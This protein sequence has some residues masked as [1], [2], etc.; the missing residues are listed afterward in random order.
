VVDFGLARLGRPEVGPDASKSQQEP[1]PAIDLRGSG[2]LSL[3]G[4]ISG[5]PG[6]MSPEQYRGGD[7][8]SRSDQW[9]FC[10]ALFEALYGYLPF[11][12]TTLREFA[13]AVQ[14]PLHPPPPDTKVPEDV[15]VALARGMSVEPAKRFSS[16]S[17]L[18]TALSQEQRGG[19]AAG[20][21]S[22]RRFSTGILLWAFTAFALIQLRQNWHHQVS[23]R[24]LILV[25]VC[26]ISFGLIGGLWRRRTLLSN[27]FHRHVWILVMATFLQNFLLRLLGAVHHLPPPELYQLEQVVF[28]GSLTIGAATLMRWLVFA[29]AIPILGMVLSALGWV[30]QRFL[31]STYPLIAILF[32]IG[33]SRAAAKEAKR[34]A[35][36]DSGAPGA[37]R[38][39]RTP[40]RSSTNS[41]EGSNPGIGPASITPSSQPVITRPA[42]LS[43]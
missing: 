29:P 23:Y 28:V 31:A 40:S 3:P 9:S 8:D 6:Y 24:N 18:L 11:S 14:G 17:E 12:G 30:P 38:K 1:L 25:S 43:P 19:S 2:R 33:W 15:Y 21:I 34:A 22:R 26:C 7:V 39:R 36:A 4:I 32:A 37:Y 27:R 16:M 35:A 13:D 41:G 10:A 20:M 42:G 5:T